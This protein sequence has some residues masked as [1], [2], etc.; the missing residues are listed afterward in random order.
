MR[1]IDL[2]KE[3]SSLKYLFSEN[4]GI[5]GVSI[6]SLRDSS[7]NLVFSVSSAK[8]K[9][10]ARFSKKTTAKDILFELEFVSSLRKN[11]FPSP[12]II[13][14]ISQ[15]KFCLYGNIFVCVLFRFYEG[16]VIDKNTQ[17]IINYTRLA[18]ENLGIL[19]T[20]SE[21][22]KIKTPRKRNIITELERAIEKKDIFTSEFNDGNLFIEKI[23]WAINFSKK[24][25]NNSPGGIIHNDYRM[26][27][28]IFTNSPMIEVVLDFDWSCPGP[29]IKDVALALVEWSFPDG[30]EQ[31]N[32][33]ILKSF[34]DAYNKTCPAKI[35]LDE[36]MYDW[37]KF[38]CL[39]DASTYFCDRINNK[40]LKKDIR[41]SYMYQ[42]Y[43]YFNQLSSA[44]K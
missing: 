7:D 2:E 29:F 40:N 13:P 4:Y 12:E 5:K 34:L 42:K 43:K 9:Y 44:R 8:N 18:G 15:N 24:E 33:D 14:T 25:G 17:N 11:D 30:D 20:I 22:I 26:H 10:I 32:L 3:I 19:H 27:N 6:A 37:I 1:K 28:L 39:S 41:K 23:K 38:S 16:I 31:P 21:K 36:K 35:F